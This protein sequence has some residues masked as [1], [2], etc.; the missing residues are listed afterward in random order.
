[1]KFDVM[2]DKKKLMDV[3]WQT[4][5]DATGYGGVVLARIDVVVRQ[6]DALHRSNSVL[7]GVE[8]LPHV[9]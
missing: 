6:A 4:K 1:M 3:V 8:S 7:H 9:R 5:L 2:R